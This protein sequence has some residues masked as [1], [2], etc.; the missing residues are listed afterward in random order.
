MLLKKE[1]NT[2]QAQGRL[3]KQKLKFTEGMQND[4][5]RYEKQTCT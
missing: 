1:K 2:N 3:I 5:G 4:T